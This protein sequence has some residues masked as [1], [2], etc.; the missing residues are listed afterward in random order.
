VESKW[1]AEGNSRKGKMGRSL[2]A[3]RK[4][5]GRKED[6]ALGDTY[7]CTEQ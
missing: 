4:E 5:G 7:L 6:A 2:G 1:E 3:G